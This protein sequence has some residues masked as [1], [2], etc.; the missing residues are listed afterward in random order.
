MLTG[1]RQQSDRDPRLCRSPSGSLPRVGLTFAIGLLLA[2]TLQLGQSAL[3]AQEKRP[4]GSKPATG[5]KTPAAAPA[6]PAAGNPTP[7]KLP[8][9]SP[10]LPGEVGPGEYLVPDKDGK[11]QHLLN[12][13][14]EDFI[15]LYKLQHRLE[16]QDQ[17]PRYVIQNIQLSGSATLVGGG[18]AGG[19]LTSNSTETPRAELTAEFTI[20]VRESGWV[21]IPLRLPNAIVREKAT[22]EGSGE[23]IFDAV[24]Q[25]GYVSWIRSEP[26]KTH[27]VTLKLL[28][29][30]VSV[31]GESQL[32]LALPRAPLSQLKLEV[33]TD[34]AVAR[35]SEG[36]ELLKPTSVPGGKTLLTALRIGGDFELAWHAAEGQ[37]AVV[38]TVLEATGA[39]F[40]RID[41]HSV[42][43][44]AKLTVR[45]FG[46]QFDRFQLRLPPAAELV[47][48]NQ[49]GVQLVPVEGVEA[50][51]QLIEVKLAR[52]TAGPVELRLVTERPH[53]L[54]RGDELLELAGFQV[55]GA[56][57]QWGYLAVQVV[58][59]WQVA[60]GPR[61]NCR[62]VDELPES[63]R[64]DDLT[65]GFEF[66]VQPFSLT[67]RVVPQKTRTS[68][69]SEFVALVG[70][71][72]V[73]LQARCKY[74]VRGAKLRAVEIDLPNWEL[75]EVGP[76]GMFNFDASPVAE[77]VTR[78]I[79]LVQPA[80]GQFEVTLRAHRIIEA[81]DKSLSFELPRP[82]ADTSSQA[83]LAVL[84]ADNV[85][86]VPDLESTFGLSSQTLK[87]AIKLPER[88]Q[89]PLFYRSEGSTA[90][91][92]AALKVHSQ[93]ISVDAL[94]TILVDEQVVNVDQRFVYQIAFEPVDS[95]DINVPRLLPLDA[96][97]VTL[98]GQR[99]TAT[100]ARGDIGA[101]A[102]ESTPL[103]L[104]LPGP[105]IG[106]CELKLNYAL[107]H[108]K[109]SPATS[110]SLAVPLVTPGT[111]KL[112]HNQL[113]V[114]PQAGVL[115]SPR[116]STWTADSRSPAAPGGGL[117]MSSR[118]APADIPLAVELKQRQAEGKTSIECG[119]VQTMLADRGRQD[120]ATYRFKS[121]EQKLRIALPLGVEMGSLEARLNGRPVLAGE[122]DNPNEVLIALAGDSREEHVLELRYDVLQF[123][124]TGN[125]RM[126]V[127]LPEFRPNTWVRRLYWELV[128]PATEHL[129]SGPARFASESTWVRD[130]VLWH[131][132]PALD[133]ADLESL[134][135]GEAGLPPRAGTNRY[136]FSTVGVVAPLE[137]WV[138]SR[139]VLV[140]AAS[141]GLLGLG[142]LLIY[143]PPA[144]HPG[145]ILVLAVC[146]LAASLIQP[147]A[148]LLLAQASSLG[149]ALAFLA[150][151]LAR[152]T[153]RRPH[154]VVTSR[155]SSRAVLDRSATPAF[156][157]SSKSAPSTTATAVAM[158]VS[159]PEEEP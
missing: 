76:A 132:E 104:A 70:A 4:A 105:R 89:D 82:H 103:R 88:Q 60:W 12:F 111:G 98:D 15:G 73:Q 33:P 19:G 148:A 123:D 110:L 80:A 65:A 134:V 100:G 127:Q 57:R 77:T 106:R 128:A 28:V 133:Q 55:V 41:G 21:R 120:R 22:Y 43:T 97:S 18:A 48:A 154:K 59:D 45:S 71:H 26:G 107:A 84:P 81:G 126:E 137:V 62:Q 96:L 8:A 139:S 114:S 157:R 68:V 7:A 30:L 40:A 35:V 102:A 113:H 152:K 20:D 29:P 129:L 63:L 74:T 144:R 95:L 69:E 46:G 85:E 93:S 24:E 75:D 39:M 147:E 36:S 124:R 122:S 58:G 14:F 56:V 83:L 140:F 142:L 42:N 90:R 150:A 52:K 135:G 155:G 115:V 61:Q 23:H 38:P 94:S 25:E 156:Y 54:A 17:K 118:E 16:N 10:S 158:Q 53:N 159:S 78:I 92:A 117:V 27:V 47:G 9:A 2:G 112:A 151:A 121:G 44:E 145:L 1:S 141:L 125:G 64:R 91:F 116:K 101:E 99:L 5:Q 108:D 31:G 6:T 153:L 87:P 131:R 119:W 79:P 109:L 143:F 11:L 34:H 146:I 136:L 66:Y 37:L 130:G 138:V 51:G 86:L 67:A 149:L 32:K 49:P 72:Q 3:Q 13:T 50:G